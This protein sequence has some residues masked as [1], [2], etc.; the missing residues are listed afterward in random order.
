MGP[1]CGLAYL[2]GRG[3][4]CL[5]AGGQA[6]NGAD[7]RAGGGAGAG[8]GA[9]RWGAAAPA[10]ILTPSATMRRLVNMT[11]LAVADAA[12]LREAGAA[13]VKAAAR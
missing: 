4:A 3:P 10:H 13:T 7:T 1:Q 6:G 5:L 12:E 9:T 11:A 2:A 8:D